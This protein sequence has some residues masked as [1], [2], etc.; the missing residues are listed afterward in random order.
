MASKHCSQLH[1]HVIEPGMKCVSALVALNYS[2]L[3]QLYCCSVFWESNLVTYTS[4][5]NT[6][7]NNTV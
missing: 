2:Y 6:A 7:W 1:I 3:K 4:L 5:C